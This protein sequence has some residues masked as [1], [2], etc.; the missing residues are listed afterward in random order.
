MLSEPRLNVLVQ[1]GR[2]L[3]DLLRNVLAD[4]LPK[5]F[6]AQEF[7][8]FPIMY[9]SLDLSMKRHAIFC[10]VPMVSMVFAELTPIP[11]EW[12]GLH[13]RWPSECWIPL[14]GREHL[15]EADVQRCKNFILKSQWLCLPRLA[16]E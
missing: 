3:L 11:P 15:G 13:L 7:D 2:Y 9:E 14:N 1:H 5:S 6:P 12:V 10:R 16:F 4:L 8:Q